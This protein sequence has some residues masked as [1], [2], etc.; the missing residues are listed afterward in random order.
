MERLSYYLVDIGTITLAISFLL[1]VIHTTLLALGRR[2]ATVTATAGAGAGGGTT[3]YSFDADRPSGA[4]TAGAMGQAF[5]W[6]SFVLIALGMLIRAILVGRGPWGNLYER[7]E[8][9]RVGKECRSRWSP[10]H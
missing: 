6:A 10:Y 8:E 2:Q 1:L 7:S 5:V 9:R 3:S 4:A